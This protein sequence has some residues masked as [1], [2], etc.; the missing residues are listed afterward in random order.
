[1]KT[2]N[3]PSADFP[4]VPAVTLTAPDDWVSGPPVQAL[5]SV[6]AP[7]ESPGFRANIV[8]TSERIVNP[9]APEALASGI[10]SRVAD[11]PQIAFAQDRI[12]DVDGRS[13]QVV[14]YSYAHPEAGTIVQAIL[15]VPVEH[16]GVIDLFEIVGSAAADR[17]DN[18]F[19]TAIQI[20]RSFR[21]TTVQ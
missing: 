18:D 11:L 3:Y 20:L 8:V 13:G 7:A 4:G 19:A 1:M 15:S 5:V 2:L 9:P 12:V 21:A 14:Q 17:I 6:L 16:D 10:R